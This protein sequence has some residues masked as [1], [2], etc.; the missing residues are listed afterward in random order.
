ITDELDLSESERQ[1]LFKTSVDYTLCTKGVGKPLMSVEFDG[2]G[3]GFSR[4]GEYVQVVPA[5]DPYRKL[6]LDLKLRVAKE[7]DYPLIVV[8]YDEKFPIGP[9]T[10]LTIVDGII[11]NLMAHKDYRDK[12]PK[13][14]EEHRLHVEQLPTEERFLYV[15]ELMSDTKYESSM[16]WDPI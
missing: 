6:K 12:L 5:S 15:S 1:F 3:H 9:S 16:I 11:G 13:V 8:S 4:R 10:S 7:V 14:I 2:L